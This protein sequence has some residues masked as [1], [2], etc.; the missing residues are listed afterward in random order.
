MSASDTQIIHQ[1]LELVV[2]KLNLL[3]GLPASRVKQV[4]GSLIIVELGNP[5]PQKSKGEYS[6]YTKGGWE[7]RKGKE[8][9]VDW[10]QYTPAETIEF[11]NIHSLGTV[12][13]VQLSMETKQLLLEFD[14]GMTLSIFDFIYESGRSG[15]FSL[16]DRS[17]SFHFFWDGKQFSSEE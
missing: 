13:K 2:E 5:L 16:A 6:L 10:T 8:I 9:L 17:F 3:V 12:K 7:V 1:P 15:W 14:S 4:Y 11:F